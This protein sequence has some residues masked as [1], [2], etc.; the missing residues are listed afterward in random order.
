M[1]YLE[2]FSDF[3]YS[4]SPGIIMVLEQVWLEIT[5]IT[6]IVKEFIK[7]KDKRVVTTIIY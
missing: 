7:G 6:Q 3:K 2:L 1:I 5:F 4:T